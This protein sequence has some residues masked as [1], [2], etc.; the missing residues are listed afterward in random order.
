M[1]RFCKKNLVP[2]VQ[3]TY[4]GHHFMHAQESLLKNS[5]CRR[6]PARAGILLLALVSAFLGLMSPFFQKIFVDH[7]LGGPMLTQ[8]WQGFEWV[9][10]TSP[11]LMIGL[12]FVCAVI[13]QSLSLIASYV[14][15]REGVIL[16]KEFSERLYRKML[17]IRTDMMAGTTVGEV[18]SIYATDVPGSTAIIDQAIPMGAGI[19]FP[20]ILAPLAIFWICGIPIW[21][22]VLVML[23]IIGLNV[24]LSTRQSRFFFRF[25]QLAAERTGLV[26][27]WIQNIRLL[28]ILGWIDH[29]ETKIFTKREEETQNRVAMV[30]NGQLMGSFGSSVSFIVNLTG[31]ASLV[32]LRDKPVTPG[33]LFALLWI[34]GVFLARPFRQIPWIFTFSLDSISSIKRLERFLRR[35]EVKDPLNA[36]SQTKIA[37]S[38][39][40]LRV[41]GLRLEI[42]GQK[43][44][45]EIN[46]DIAAGEF[47]AVVGEVGSGKSLL[48]YS[49]MGE[50]G[51]QFDE[52]RIGD[53][54]VKSL[55]LNSRRR[56]FAFVP[57]EGFVMSASLRDNVMLSYSDV[58]GDDE[59]I[60][61][62]LRRAQFRLETEHVQDGLETEIGE[63]GVNLSGG[64]RQR[65]SLA[66]ADHFNRPIVLLDDCL[67][68][69]DVD[70]ESLLIQDLIDGVWCERT[71]ILITHRLSV[72][73]RVDRI[74]L[75][76]G[77]RIV[78]SGTFHE[79]MASSQRMR[80]FVVSV[81]RQET[82]ESHEQTGEEARD[83]Q[84]ESVS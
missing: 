61:G 74:L 55:E 24:I 58:P 71:R 72:L 66:R 64:Q 20:L 47:V 54:D 16:Q 65:V 3:V 57:Q 53:T 52:F 11:L 67:S 45:N 23:V 9:E 34:F 29:Y 79:L 48:V 18:V 33:E 13:A 19:L 69:L 31:V 10:G 21:T 14:G 81:R 41:R 42:G 80:D 76:D 77:G 78:E 70:T 6:F 39:L 56:H 22:T 12:A 43:I 46:L 37:S 73:E 49:L 59:T 38:A 62:S 25:K 63:R 84:A 82:Q 32:F 68:A 50:T 26:N 36:V 27:E 15:L 44:L 17:G 5:F 30:T 60:L 51:A 8:G 75:M 40:P 4:D 1:R 83:V 7:L 28:R 35:E 2:F